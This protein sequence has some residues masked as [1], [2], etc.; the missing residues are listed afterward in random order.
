MIINLTASSDTYITN[1]IIDGNYSL[2]SN[3]G[4]AGTLDLFT[5]YDESSI[6]N[7][8]EISRA[9][10]KFDLEKLNELTSSILD[11]SKMKSRIILKSIEAGNPV[12]NNFTLCSFPLAKEFSEGIGRDIISFSDIGVASYASASATT[13]WHITGCMNGQNVGVANADYFTH[14]NFGS[15]LVSLKSSKVFIEGNEDL[16]LDVTT[17]ISGSMSGFFQNNGFRISY[18]ESQETDGM[19]RFVKRFGSRHVKNQLLSPYLEIRFDDSRIDE[20]NN[21]YF[22]S[23]GSIF[24]NASKNGVSS[25][26]TNQSGS[27]ISGNNCIIVTL[28]TGSFHAHF[29]GSQERLGNFIDGSYFANISISS[30]DQAIVSGSITLAQHIGASG[31][32]EFNEVWKSLDGAKNFYSGKITVNATDISFSTSGNQR[33][34]SSCNGPTEISYN[35]KSEIRV[36]FYDLSEDEYASRFYIEKKPLYL[37]DA[38]Y[39]IRDLHSNELVFDFDNDYTKLSLDN[40]GN[41]FSVFGSTFYRGRNYSLEFKVNYKGLESVV[42]D[43][44]YTFK[45]L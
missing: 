10:I 33:I 8:Y 23:T 27:E 14:C 45:V 6:N 35:D 31:S 37:T 13:A 39:R 17:S 38:K 34:I 12:P 41:Y 3:V 18:D 22:D 30:N 11:I 2:E 29:T 36:K 15:G 28:S 7:S 20:R 21:L 5:L 40:L 32:I 26:L 1:K 9:L 42:K 4:K 16:S 25:N 24:L 43:E 19:S 44:N